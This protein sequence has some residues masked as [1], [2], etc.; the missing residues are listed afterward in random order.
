MDILH[1]F[2][3]GYE[4]KCLCYM[5]RAGKP[6][7]SNH[8]MIIQSSG[9]KDSSCLFNDSYVRSSWGAFFTIHH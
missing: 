1:I 4:D 3:I 7:S 9:F 8:F 6:L 5:P 2:N